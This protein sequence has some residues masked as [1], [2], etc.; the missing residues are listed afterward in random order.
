MC[1]TGV[2][3]EMI[4]LM[5]YYLNMWKHRHARIHVAENSTEQFDE[6]HVIITQSSVFHLIV[7]LFTKYYI[8]DLFV[9]QTHVKILSS[10]DW[11]YD[12]R[13]NMTTHSLYKDGNQ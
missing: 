7:T 9:S 2:T 1:N 8:V 10:I 12:F 11:I 5:G 4:I 3:S 13:I 6:D